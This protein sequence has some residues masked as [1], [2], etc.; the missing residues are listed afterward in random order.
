[1]LEEF[2]ARVEFR[3]NQVKKTFL[4]NNYNLSEYQAVTDKLISDIE[5]ELATAE[6]TLQ[7]TMKDQDGALD[8]YHVQRTL[9]LET[10]ADELERMKALSQAHADG[11]Q[12]LSSMA[13]GAMSAANGIAGVI[14]SES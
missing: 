3:L 4:D 13:S 14:L 6:A 2:T 1:M 5:V 9:L 7:F 11:S 8:A 10:A 12:V